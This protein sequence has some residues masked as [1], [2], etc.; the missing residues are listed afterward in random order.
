MRSSRHWTPRYIVDRIRVIIHEKL[1]PSN[2]WLTR[3]AVG[4]LDQLLRPEDIALE[5]GG[6][7][8]TPWFARH[9]KQ[10]LTSVDDNAQWQDFAR[11]RIVAA[12]LSNVDFLLCPREV[13]EERGDESLYVRTVDKFAD[14]SIDFVLVDGIYRAQCALAVL[15]KLSEGALLAVD[16]ANWFLPSNSI[17]PNSRRDAEGP[18]NDVWRSFWEQTSTWRRIWTDS[19]VTATLLMFKP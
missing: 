14:Q 7:R 12:K 15:P 11:S 19:G 10:H 6:G 18:A 2:P 9:V 4:H 13:P 17:A 16:N 5:F 8:S 3:E 1:N